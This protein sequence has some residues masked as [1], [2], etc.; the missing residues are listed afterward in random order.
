MYAC[1]WGDG[2]TT[3]VLL[4]FYMNIYCVI[5]YVF[6]TSIV[7][8]HDVFDIFGFVLRIWSPFIHFFFSPGLSQC[9]MNFFGSPNSEARSV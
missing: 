8:N 2:S 3:Y 7:L 9:L 1:L 4:W 5:I 6:E